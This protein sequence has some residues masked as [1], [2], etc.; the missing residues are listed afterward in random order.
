M[1]SM[2][3]SSRSTSLAIGPRWSRGPCL[4]RPVVLIKGSST[5]AANHKVTCAASSTT[6]ATEDVGNDT[7]KQPKQ[8]ARIPAN[9]ADTKRHSRSAGSS[10][11]QD[12][13][14]PR[15]ATS[16]ST[17]AGGGS[18]SDPAGAPSHR[19]QGAGANK[20]QFSGSRAKVSQQIS[21][22]LL[23]VM[24]KQARTPEQLA[25]LV[26]RHAGDLNHIHLSA[27]F[28]RAKALRA[29]GVPLQLLP[30]LLSLLR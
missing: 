30:E 4:L 3:S 28:T 9:A 23:T 13:K 25:Q 12:S 17:T 22:Q 18:A 10:L 21:P 6:S 7:P 11:Q 29:D 16:S 26:Q 5:A 15:G 19:K 8:P 27:A 24:L 20:H 1:L 2:L 14:R